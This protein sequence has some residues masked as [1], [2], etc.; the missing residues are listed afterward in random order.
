[1]TEEEEN[2]KSYAIELIKNKLNFT[3]NDVIKMKPYLE[4]N[5]TVFDNLKEVRTE[6]CYCILL[7][8]HQAA[9]T[10][11]NHLLENTLKTGL[12]YNEYGFKMIDDFNQ[13]DM[14]YKEGLN[15][16]NRLDLQN[17]INQSCSKGLITKQEKKVLNKFRERFR[18][19]FSHSDSRKIL[20]DIKIPLWM[21]KFDNKEN[22]P[23]QHIECNISEVPQLFGIA[24]AELAK[25]NSFNYFSS[26]FSVLKNIEDKLKTQKYSNGIG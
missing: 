5:L 15:K 9:I 22:E 6:I 25:N 20:K 1:L 13:M 23:L 3:S 11:T 24:K 14:N 21:G 12:I 26:V 10:L 19:G 18:N 16:Y 8:L 7:D 17:T 4:Y 2:I